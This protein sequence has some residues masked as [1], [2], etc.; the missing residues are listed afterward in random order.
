MG[1]APAGLAITDWTNHT[2]VAGG[3]TRK[4]GKTAVVRLTGMAVVDDGHDDLDPAARRHILTLGL[5]RVPAMDDGHPDPVHVAHLLRVQFGITERVAHV[6]CYWGNYIVGMAT[7][8]AALTGETAPV[9]TL[10]NLSP[11][12]VQ[13]TLKAIREGAAL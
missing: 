4:H 10:Y 2:H 1:F 12:E 7:R 8:P 9:A 6:G 11:M 5:F 13:L 3:L